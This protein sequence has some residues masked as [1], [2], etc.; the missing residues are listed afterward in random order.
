VNGS[1]GPAALVAALATVGC[2]DTTASPPA[3]TAQYAPP[4]SAPG[5]S[6][7]APYGGAP[8]ISQYG[9]P[10]PAPYT[11]PQPAPYNAPQPAPYGVPPPS[12]PGAYAGSTPAANDT[13]PSQ[14]S[15]PWSLPR[16]TQPPW[17]LPTPSTT[18]RPLL[19]PLIGPAAWQAES[20]AVVS[21]LVASLSPQNQARVASVP[22]VFD[23]N[24]N[25]VNAFAGCD[26][27]GA[28]FI[29]GTEGLL[30]A[31]DGIAQ[32]KATDELY[33]SQA[34]DAYV[35][36]VA[37]RLLSKDGG[38]A[39]LPVGI[40]PVKAWVDLRRISRAHEI[41]DEIVA[42]TF[43]HEL[44]HHYLG[45]TGCA[46]GQ[47]GGFGPAIAQLD[48]LAASMAP[49]I[50]QPNESAADTSGCINLLDAGRARSTSAYR[51]NEEGG[52]WLLDFFARLDRASGSNPWLGFL[53]THPNPAFRIPLVQLTATTWRFQH[54]S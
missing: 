52:L 48:Q 11:A 22:L 47:T 29:A 28:P 43:G 35:S 3:Q 14:A 25:Q 46:S 5:A 30:E 50:N 41:F 6:P 54:P 24:P 31:I 13:A 7:P 17:S 15:P 10:Q 53:R 26:D 12:P 44:S 32:T 38:S 1:L 42:F 18:A 36:T 37:P 16:T 40:V 39:L 23:P 33:G 34:Y 27:A 21:E 9:A 20:R 45:H 19:A 8:P 2:A 49:I 51:W 4:T